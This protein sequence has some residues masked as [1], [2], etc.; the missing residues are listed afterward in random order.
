MHNLIEKIFK[1]RGIAD[2][3]DLSEEEKRDFDNWQKILSKDTLTIED[4]RQFLQ[5]QIDVITGKWQ[6]YSL[7]NTK[8]AEMIAY[9]TCYKTIL[10][11]LDSPK[12]AREQ[13]EQQLNLLL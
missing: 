1:K 10:Q 2:A 8:K 11:V 9:F 6:D 12:Q 4:L 7:E 3:N 5:N 13:L